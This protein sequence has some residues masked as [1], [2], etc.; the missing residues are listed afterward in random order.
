MPSRAVIDDFLNQERLAVVGVSRNP[1]E[2][3][4]AI[5]RELR[6]HGYKV[7]PVNPSA[8]EVEGVPCY[9][10]VRDLPEP[11]DGVLVMVPAAQAAGVVRDCQAAGVTRVWLHRGAGPGAV[12]PEAVGLARQAGMA[13]VDGA[14]P[15]MFLGGWFH[16]VHRFFTRLDP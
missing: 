3:Q 1:Q 15:M 6:R 14:C 13:L 4:N 5:F 2:M 8:R 7:L 9:P 11:V 16:Q 10:S 12:S